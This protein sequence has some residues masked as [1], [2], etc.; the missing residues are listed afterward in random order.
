VAAGG[1]AKRLLLGCTKEIKTASKIATDDYAVNIK[2]TNLF[3]H[4]YIQMSN[5]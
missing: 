2:V 4:S 5:S 3:S 1:A